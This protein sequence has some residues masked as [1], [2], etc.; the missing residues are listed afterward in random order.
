MD[1]KKLMEEAQKYQEKL[2]KLVARFR[3]KC[4]KTHPTSHQIIP[5]AIKINPVANKIN[6]VASKIKPVAKKMVKKRPIVLFKIIF[7]I[8]TQIPK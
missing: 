8:N 5:V 3:H 7:E 6:P 1:Y 2:L 4:N